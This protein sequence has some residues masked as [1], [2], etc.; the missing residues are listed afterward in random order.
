M[1]V[2]GLYDEFISKARYMSNAPTKEQTNNIK[3]H[4]TPHNGMDV[5]PMPSI[6]YT[7]D[8]DIQQILYHN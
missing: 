7:L 5:Y 4:H 6:Y 3:P 2:E 8:N 1:Q